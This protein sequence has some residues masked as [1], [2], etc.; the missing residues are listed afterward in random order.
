MVHSAVLLQLDFL[1]LSLALVSAS[2]V[3][4]ILFKIIIHIDMVILGRGGSCSY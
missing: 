1:R 3:V 2:A 4:A